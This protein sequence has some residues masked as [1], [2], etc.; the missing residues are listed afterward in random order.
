MVR[1]TVKVHFTVALVILNWQ[2]F[3]QLVHIIHKRICRPN[4]GWKVSIGTLFACLMLPHI[5]INFYAF[6]FNLS[7]PFQPFDPIRTGS[8]ALPNITTRGQHHTS[9]HPLLVAE[10]GQKYIWNVNQGRQMAET[11][12]FSHNPPW[13][14]KRWSDM[15]GHKGAVEAYWKGSCVFYASW[16]MPY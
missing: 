5:I 8:K 6:V 10:C 7:P 4:S 13:K 16:F 14:A 11:E 12:V 1:Q 15:Y 2:K 9:G 3:Q